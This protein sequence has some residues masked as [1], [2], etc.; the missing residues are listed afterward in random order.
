MQA[1]ITETIAEKCFICS[2]LGPNL[3]EMKVRTFVRMQKAGLKVN[4]QLVAY[5]TRFLALRL[6]IVWSHHCALKAKVQCDFSS[7]FSPD[8]TNILQLMHADKFKRRYNR[9]A[10]HQNIFL[11]SL[12]VLFVIFKSNFPV[13]SPYPNFYLFPRF[14][15]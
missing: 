6:K 7:A 12:C 14:V 13:D 2:K 4:D 8:R 10:R 1:S 5:A 11:S 9:T 15:L 3:S